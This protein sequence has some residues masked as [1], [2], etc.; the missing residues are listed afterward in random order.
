[1][2][3]FRLIMAQKK[4]N[5]NGRMG[6]NAVTSCISTM[7]MLLLLGITVFFVTFARHFSNQLRENFCITLLL[8]DEM[9][10][11]ETQSLKNTL[12]ELP[13]C[14]QVTYISKEQ[15]LKEQSAAMGSDPSEFMGVNPMPAS[16]EMFLHADYAQGDSLGVLLPYLKAYPKVVDVAYPETLME[17]LNQNIRRVSGV[18]LVLA[19]LL[20]LVSFVLINNTIR[21]SVFSR[22]V[23][24]HTMKLVGASWSF[25]RRPFLL[26]ALG[27]GLTSAMLATGI[28]AIGLWLMLR[29]EADM[30]RLVTWDVVVWTVG[31]IFVCGLLLTLGCAF[32]TVNHVLRMRVQHIYR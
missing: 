30:L 13:A 19:L 5:R 23:L 18:L 26:Q 24:I 8:D 15:A 10:Q 14:R 16:F 27:I 25:I 11:Q 2:H 7:L 20:M 21:L 29:Y 9:T 31:S 32:A 12:Q 1:M 28:L 3:D 4:Q 6:V 22:R 17:S